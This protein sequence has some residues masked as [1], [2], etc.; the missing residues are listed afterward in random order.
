MWPYV[1]GVDTCIHFSE[2]GAQHE[3]EIIC[4]WFCYNYYTTGLKV[5]ASRHDL[6]RLGAR[7]QN[8]AEAERILLLY[9]SRS[10]DLVLRRD[11]WQEQMSLRCCS[12]HLT[13]FS[14]FFNNHCKQ[15]PRAA[16]A[17]VDSKNPDQNRIIPLYSESALYENCAIVF[18]AKFKKQLSN[19]K[20]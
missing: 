5:V 19:N 6:F 1:F 12:N 8:M 15:H 4:C 18:C 11:A 17:A 14:T 7:V 20:E 10:R 13:P 16:A 3:R 2:S 9:A